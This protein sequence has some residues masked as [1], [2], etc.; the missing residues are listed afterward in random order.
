MRDYLQGQLEIGNQLHHILMV[1]QLQFFAYNSVNVNYF[2]N[3][4]SAMTS[5]DL[6]SPKSIYFGSLIAH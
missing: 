3:Q 6:I 5:L 4:H 1:D 2:M